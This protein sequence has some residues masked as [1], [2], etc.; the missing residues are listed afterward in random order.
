MNLT[1]KHKNLFLSETQT[2]KH[3]SDT[4]FRTYKKSQELAGEGRGLQ[5]STKART[6][7]QASKQTNK[8]NPTETK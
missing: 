6:D 1:T 5:S 7:R 3:P 4:N 8:Q 2:S